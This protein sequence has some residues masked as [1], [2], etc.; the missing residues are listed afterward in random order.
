M[1]KNG[2]EKVNRGKKEILVIL[3]IIKFKKK[4]KRTHRWT[5]ENKR[6]STSLIKKKTTKA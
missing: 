3:S 5:I 1:G 4:K 6:C 2:V